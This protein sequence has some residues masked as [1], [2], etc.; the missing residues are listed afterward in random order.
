MDYSEREIESRAMLI[1]SKKSTSLSRTGASDVSHHGSNVEGRCRPLTWCK[2]NEWGRY[3]CYYGGTA[4]SKHIITTAPEHSR[5]PD[6]HLPE[7]EKLI[8]P[9]D[10][11]RGLLSTSLAKA[12][13]RAL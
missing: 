4:A 7:A 2:Y 8:G 13:D 6:K 10:L 5:K 12:R 11:S 9:T 1:R 3:C